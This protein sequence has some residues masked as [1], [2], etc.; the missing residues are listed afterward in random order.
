MTADEYMELALTTSNAEFNPV[1]KE[2]LHSAFGCATEA[3]ELLDVLK[4]VIFY[5]RA[6]DTINML[7]EFGDMLWYI[8]LG[9]H[10]LGFSFDDAF[11]R[12]IAKLR[13]RYPDGEFNV[14]HAQERDLETE[15]KRLEN[16]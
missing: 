13:A 7:E 11:Q 5:G 4:K 2:L 1:D 3:G 16:K 8:A 14:T 9:L 6:I 15:R 12:N 10:A